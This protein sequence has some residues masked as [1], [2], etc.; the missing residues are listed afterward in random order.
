MV[1]VSIM[2]SF[3]TTLGARPFERLRPDFN[4]LT[5][6]VLFSSAL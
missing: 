5:L 4:L 2:S 3:L 6:Q 1:R